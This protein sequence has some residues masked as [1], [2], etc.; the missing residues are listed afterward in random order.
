MTKLPVHLDLHGVSNARG[1]HPQRPEP[2][3]PVQPVRG[4]RRH[5]VLSDRSAAPGKGRLSIYGRV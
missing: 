3:L 2:G 5:R 4:L 1:I